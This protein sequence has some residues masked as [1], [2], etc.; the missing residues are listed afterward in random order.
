MKKFI[1]LLVMVSCFVLP[2][3]ALSAEP[4]NVASKGFTEQVRVVSGN[5]LDLNALSTN[6]NLCVR[7]RQPKSAVAENFIEIPGMRRLRI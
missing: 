3:G 6:W 1:A 2:L 7:R 5:V 4:V